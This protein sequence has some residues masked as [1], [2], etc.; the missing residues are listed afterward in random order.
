MFS[1]VYDEVTKRVVQLRKD[2]GLTQRELAARLGRELSFISRIEQGQRR[3]DLVE[4][5]WLCHA[6][7]ADPQEVGSDL[8]AAIVR[9]G[10]KRQRGK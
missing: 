7:D 8:L 1:P 5:V 9:R 6:C 4:F 2:A 10:G 3:L